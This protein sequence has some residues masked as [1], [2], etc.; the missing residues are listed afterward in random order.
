MSIG[1][2]AAESSSA[3]SAVRSLDALAVVAASSALRPAP[4]SWRVRPR[5]LS[6]V[7]GA[8]IT[9]RKQLRLALWQ[10][11]IGCSFG[12]HQEKDLDSNPLSLLPPDEL[13][14]SHRLTVCGSS[15]PASR[16]TRKQRA[17]RSRMARHEA[18][19]L[20]ATSHPHRPAPCP[21]AAAPTS[22]SPAIENATVGPES[23]SPLLLPGS[24]Y[25]SAEHRGQIVSGA[26]VRCSPTRHED[27]AAA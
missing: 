22:A 3:S 17:R 21:T 11:G 19:T 2:H 6:P 5:R 25:R 26:R 20:P 27:T 10:E 13:E 12:R 14:A 4:A 7:N 9:T 8:E 1:D 18:Q 15:R 16:G 23:P 24:L